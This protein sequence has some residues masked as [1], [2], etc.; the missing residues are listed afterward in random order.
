M[1]MEKTAD[2]TRRQQALMQASQSGTCCAKQAI[3]RAA[4][5]KAVRMAWGTIPVPFGHTIC[6]R[7]SPMA[8]DQPSPAAFKRAGE[9]VFFFAPG[10]PHRARGVF[11]FAQGD[12]FAS[13]CT[14][15]TLAPTRM[16]TQTLRRTASSRCLPSSRQR[17]TQSH[18]AC[19]T[20]PLLVERS[21][22][23]P[24]QT[25]VQLGTSSTRARVIQLVLLEG[26]PHMRAHL[27]P[28][29]GRSRTS[30]RSS[31]A[32]KPRRLQQRPSSNVVSPLMSRSPC[33]APRQPSITAKEMAG[34]KRSERADI[35]RHAAS[36]GG[37]MRAH[38]IAGE[39][40]C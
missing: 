39:S 23:K 26:Q 22:P 2:A 20:A 11:F 31:A 7:S 28:P 27:S 33:S 12:F 40:I 1:E 29:S 38:P 3:L 4:K 19:R 14:I 17:S 25:S 36:S 18:T 6:S 24:A 35:S 15:S 9:R 13:T 32:A 30:S 8:A 21:S 10:C 16:G 5:A 37:G 34:M